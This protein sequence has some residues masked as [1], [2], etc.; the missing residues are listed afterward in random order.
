[1]SMQIKETFR[2][3]LAHKQYTENE[4]DKREGILDSE[5][6]RGSAEK[7]C[8]ECLIIV[9][10]CKS[11]HFNSDEIE[12]KDKERDGVQLKKGLGCLVKGLLNNFEQDK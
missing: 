6:N 12:C 7:S 1:M 8:D 3:M 4:S 2:E 5:N 9:K 11:T 10:N